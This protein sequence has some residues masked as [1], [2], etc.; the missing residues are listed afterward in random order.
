MLELDPSFF[1]HT[2]DIVY[3]DR[4]AKNLDLARY[5]WQYASVDPKTELREYSSGP[6]TDAHSGGFSEDQRTPMHRFLRVKGGF[7]SGIVDREDDTP[8][9]TILFHDVSGVVQ[10]EDRI[11]AASMRL[12][13]SRDTTTTAEPIDTQ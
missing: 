4:R 8:V 12:A 9:L 6:H 7:L 2:G 11:V 10:F 3:Y 5:H 13:P 1:V